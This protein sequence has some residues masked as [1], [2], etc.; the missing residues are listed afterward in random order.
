MHGHVT[1]V[2]SQSFSSEEAMEQQVGHMHKHF[3]LGFHLLS[4]SFEYVYGVIHVENKLMFLFSL[5]KLY[6]KNCSPNILTEYMLQNH[7]C[8]CIAST[9]ILTYSNCDVLSSS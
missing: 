6:D 4:G 5:T 1:A 7:R 8:I 3:I 2:H 9:F